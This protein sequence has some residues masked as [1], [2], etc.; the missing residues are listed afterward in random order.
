MD[1]GVVGVG[2]VVLLLLV[3]P[4]RAR[5]LGILERKSPGSLAFTIANRRRFSD[6]LALAG[7][8]TELG[9]RVAHFTAEPGVT[10]DLDGITFW[11]NTPPTRAGTIAWSQISHIRMTEA[12]GPSLFGR[13]AIEVSVLVDTAVI[14]VPLMSPNSTRSMRSS[15]TN[16]R[17]ITHGLAD[18]RAASLA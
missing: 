16:G 8:G 3:G 18:L 10:A 6:S 9:A 13:Y 2:V 14:I 11:D 17:S 5:T 4:V 15:R 7:V 12:P 1:L